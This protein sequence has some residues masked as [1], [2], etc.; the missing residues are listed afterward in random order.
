MNTIIRKVLG[1]SGV[2]VVLF[3][4]IA[5]GIV[6]V[7]LIAFAGPHA[8]SDVL[9][10]PL[11]EASWL[12]KALFHESDMYWAGPKWF[13]VDTLVFFTVLGTGLRLAQWGLRKKLIDSETCNNTR[14]PSQD[15]DSEQRAT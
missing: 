1:W 15:G 2:G 3:G 6:V 12:I 7:P 10:R 5:Y 14:T 11:R 8:T 13:I 4:F 9:G